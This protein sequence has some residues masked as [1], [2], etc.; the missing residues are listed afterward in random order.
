[1][2]DVVLSVVSSLHGGAL[3][4]GLGG[5]DSDPVAPPGVD[6]KTGMLLGWA[7]WACYA[8][9]VFGLIYVASCLGFANRRGEGEDSATSL[10]FVLSGAILCGAAGGR[11]SNSGSP[12]FLPQFVAAVVFL[13]VLALGAWIVGERLIGGGAE[14]SASPSAVPAPSAMVMGLNGLGKSTL[15]RRIMP[16]LAN[17]GIHRALLQSA[18][19][20][21]KNMIVS[22]IHI[23]RPQAPTDREE[24]ILNA[25]V[26]ILE[27]RGGAPVLADAGVAPRR[28]YNVIIDEMLAH[29]ARLVGSGGPDRRPDAHESVGG[30][31]ADVVHLTPQ[32]GRSTRIWPTPSW[33]STTPTSGGRCPLP[34]AV[35]AIRLRDEIRTWEPSTLLI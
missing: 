26:R 29:Y 2:N 16:G 15:I 5:M 12:L 28:H 23:V 20:S 34:K 10:A 14:G 25:A 31:G 6:T 3:R 9:C 13:V 18:H 8:I 19:E 1:M 22:L 21:K 32:G 35:R 4:A 7:K 27:E 17:R 30:C 24:V 11:S 33:T